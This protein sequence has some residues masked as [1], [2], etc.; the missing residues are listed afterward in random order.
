MEL[1]TSDNNKIKA[2]IFDL[3]NVLIKVDFERMLINHTKDATGNSAH[4]IT[5]SAYNDDLFKQFCTGELSSEKFYKKL[6]KRY[7]L[8]ISIQLFKE[9]WCDIFELVEGM[10]EL[11]AELSSNFKIGLLSDTDPI[12][13]QYVLREYPFLQSIE[14]P[15]LSYKVGYMK[16]HPDMYKLAAKNVKQSPNE[17]LFIDDQQVNVEGAQKVGMHA[18]Q[19]ENQKQIKNFLISAG[20]L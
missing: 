19:F 20:L 10:S 5:E 18:V 16:P 13:W 14:N 15:T 17:C 12:H 8:D 2:I 4:E 11:V 9:K 7:N 6:N 3:G 1:K